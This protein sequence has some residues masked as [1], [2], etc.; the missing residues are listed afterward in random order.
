VSG[1]GGRDLV[2]GG[3]GADELKC[4][5]G[6]KDIARADADDTVSASCEIVKSL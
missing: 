2:I 5:Q 1:G 4:G 3:L 6:R